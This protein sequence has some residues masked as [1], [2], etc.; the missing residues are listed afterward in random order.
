MY[1]NSGEY[2]PQSDRPHTNPKPRPRPFPFPFHVSENRNGRKLIHSVESEKLEG[3]R[4]EKAE[5]HPPPPNPLIDSHLKPHE[6][7]EG[8]YF[9][10]SLLIIW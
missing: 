2:P 1:R 9:V 3:I 6:I 10:F 8:N 7:Q 5:S 4:R